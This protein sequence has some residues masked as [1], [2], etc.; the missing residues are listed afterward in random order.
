M[1]R[2]AVVAA[3]ERRM[4]EDMRWMREVAALG[5]GAFARL[6]AFFPLASYRRRT[7]PLLFALVRL[8]AVMVEDCGPCTRIALKMALAEGVPPERLRAALDGK[9]VG[10][11][12]LVHAFGR[13]VSASDPEAAMLGDRIERQLGRD[14]RTELALAAATVRVYPAIKRGLGLGGPCSL[15]RFDDLC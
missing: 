10:D 11:E 8:G 1:I 12:E 9:L 5:R 13:A 3:A 2:D 15:A 4:R 6:A 7:P 14:V